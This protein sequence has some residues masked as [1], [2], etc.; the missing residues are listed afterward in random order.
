[1]SLPLFHPNPPDFK[2]NDILDNEYYII[3]CYKPSRSKPDNDEAKQI[4][5]GDDLRDTK[6]QTALERKLRIADALKKFDPQLQSSQIDNY[7]FEFDP[8]E[9][10]LA[11]YYEVINMESGPDDFLFD[12]FMNDYTVSIH[13]PMPPL[14]EQDELYFAHGLGYAQAIAQTEGYFVWDDMTQQAY[15]PLQSPNM[16]FTF[17]KR[18]ANEKRRRIEQEEQA[19]QAEKNKPWWKIW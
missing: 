11:A 5:F 4:C 16:G 12:L 17:Y 1:M 13:I 7:E 19:A 3:Y 6:Q 18:L 8:T 10:T 14:A 2:N 15:D 9:Q